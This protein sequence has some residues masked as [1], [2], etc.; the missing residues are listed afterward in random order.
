MTTSTEG[1]REWKSQNSKRSTEAA[2]SG[3]SRSGDEDIDVADQPIS[4]Q[5]QHQENSDCDPFT[6]FHNEHEEE[7]GPKGDDFSQ[8]PDDGAGAA[9]WWDTLPGPI[10]VVTTTHGNKR[11]RYSDG[12]WQ[13]VPAS[14]AAR[15]GMGAPT[16]R[17]GIDGRGHGG[18]MPRGQ[19]TVGEGLTTIG[20]TMGG[21][22]LGMGVAFRAWREAECLQKG[23]NVF[24]HGEG[25]NAHG[26]REVSIE[27]G[28]FNAMGVSQGE[29]NA[30]GNTMRFGHHASR[31]GNAAKTWR[32]HIHFT[33]FNQNTTKEQFQQ[34][35]D[36][37]VSL[38]DNY[39]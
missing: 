31:N 38:N 17:G 12:G 36:S 8:D 23:Q 13:S 27:R 1:G 7:E 34:D 6:D 10:N 2:R 25:L 28:Q 26:R 21:A 5:V 30:T 24:G 39:F 11:R 16:G 29:L 32:P 15:M 14:Q 35:D 33:R 18:I 22:C 3:V 37:M 20:M 4:G 9:R 19:A